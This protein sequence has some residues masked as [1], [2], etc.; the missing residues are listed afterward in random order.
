MTR[1]AS[2]ADLPL[3]DDVRRLNP[4]AAEGK[5]TKASK[6]GNVRTPTDAGMA[7]S[8]AE[9]ARWAELRLLERS[10]HIRALRFHPRYALPGGITYEADSAY[11]E[12]GHEVVEDVKGGK[13]R[14]GVFRLKWRQMAECYPHIELRIVER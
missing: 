4:D 1:I 12:D 11:Q 5:P 8:K 2:L 9:A 14:T 7:D 10:G 13:V 3:S 6:Y